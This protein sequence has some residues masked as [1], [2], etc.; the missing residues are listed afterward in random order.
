MAKG[1]IG[2]VFGASLH[3][4]LSPATLPGPRLGYRVIPGLDWI[5]EVF[6]DWREYQAGAMIG[7]HC[8]MPFLG[9]PT[10]NNFHFTDKQSLEGL[11]DPAEFARRLSFDLPAHDACQR[12]GC[13]IVEFEVLDPVRVTIPPVNQGTQRGLTHRGA[14]EWLYDGQIELSSQTDIIYLDPNG[15]M[16]Y[17]IPLD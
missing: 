12:Y 3:R 15:P 9:A 6:P 11:R 14:R 10:S 8:Q 16:H 5:Y 2:P 1:R 4:N 13:I 17:R 7:I